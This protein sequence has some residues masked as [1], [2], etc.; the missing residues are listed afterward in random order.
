MRFE[1]RELQDAIS[2]LPADGFFD[3]E[4][5]A[6]YYEFICN[7]SFVIDENHYETIDLKVGSSWVAITAVDFLEEIN[8]SIFSGEY[9][10]FRY[11]ALTN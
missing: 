7:K 1:L 3:L 11:I 5:D 9:S 2:D 4:D 8:K 6:I 10:H